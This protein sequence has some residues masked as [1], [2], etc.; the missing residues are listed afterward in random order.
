MGTHPQA[1]QSPQ[2]PTT[3]GDSGPYAHLA[4]AGGFDVLAHLPDRSGN[5]MT[6]DR[7]S[8]HAQTWQG[9]NVTIRVAG[10]EDIIASKE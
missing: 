2:S 6:F 3:T 7:L 5:F 1:A 9:H 10:L 4:D 8:Q